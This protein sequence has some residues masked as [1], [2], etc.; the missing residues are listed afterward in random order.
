MKSVS[1]WGCVSVVVL[2]LVTAGVWIGLVGRDMILDEPP[3]LCGSRIMEEGQTCERYSRSTGETTDSFG[4]EEAANSQNTA[5]DVF[6]W[7]VVAV[8]GTL[9]LAGGALVVMAVKYREDD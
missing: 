1:H 8:G 4:A 5:K 7:I 9:A 3:A 2:V 6:G